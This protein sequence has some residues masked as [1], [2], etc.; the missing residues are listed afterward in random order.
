MTSAVFVTGSGT[1]VGKTHVAVRMI[2]DWRAVGM[3]VDAL[4]PVVSGHDEAALEGSD[5]GRLLAALGR[6]VTSDSVAR[7]SPWRYAAPLSPDM[8]AA[9]EGLEVPYR[10]VVSFC[11]SAI[12]HNR[13][14]LVIEGIGGV[15]VPL[16]SERTIL[17]LIAAIA[18]PAVLVGGSYVGSLSHTL[19]ALAALRARHV[20]VERLVVSETP[21]SPAGLEETCKTLRRF[22][23]GVPVDPLAYDGRPHAPERGGL[24]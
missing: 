11:R 12:K 17:D 3:R 19:S 2:R 15:M 5:P 1:E 10:E 9:R 22:T 4:K 16:D 8:A 24:P 6:E 20:I 21:G 18:I 13:G 7:I 23:D 14:R